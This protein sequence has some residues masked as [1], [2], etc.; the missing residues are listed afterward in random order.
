M[1]GGVQRP[2]SLRELP[3]LYFR[4]AAIP[5]VAA[6]VITAV[7]A[8]LADGGA[9]AWGAALGVVLVLVFFGIDLLAMRVTANWEPTTTFGVVMVEYLGKIIALAILLVALSGQSEP[10]HVST[11]WL[12]IGLAVGCVVFLS[13]LVVAYLR[14]PTF[15]IE[16]ESAAAK[17]D[18][19][20]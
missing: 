3:G 13:A 16:P 14:V 10:Q 19:A 6:G 17:R 2:A 7:L 5:T 11:R 20:T 4:G 12:G 8:G 1:S 9:A 15:V 18:A